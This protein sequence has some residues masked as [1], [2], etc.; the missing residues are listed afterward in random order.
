MLPAATVNS[1]DQMLIQGTEKS[2]HDHK[3]AKF[4]LNLDCKEGFNRSEPIY[5]TKL[6][7]LRL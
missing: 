3:L 1:S 5:N 4:C 7:S 6:K 2:I